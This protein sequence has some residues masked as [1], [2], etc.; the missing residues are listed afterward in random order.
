MQMRTP[1]KPFS[2]DKV[3]LIVRNP[4]DVFASMFLFLNTASHSLVSEERVCEAFKEEWEYN[5][6]VMAKAY[7]EYHVHVANISK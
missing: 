7:N 6:R 5:I 4:I 1:D 2:A 3:F